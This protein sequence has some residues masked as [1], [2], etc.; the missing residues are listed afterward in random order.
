MTDRLIRNAEV[1]GVNDD[2]CRHKRSSDLFGVKVSS[3]TSFKWV[4]PDR[5]ASG[6]VQ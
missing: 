3:A 5:D 4:K 2:V 1:I 6:L